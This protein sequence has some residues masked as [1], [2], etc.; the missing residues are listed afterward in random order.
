MSARPKSDI[1]SIVSE[2][3]VQCAFKAPQEITRQTTFDELGY[4]SLSFVEAVMTLEAELGIELPGAV[5]QG[6]WGG[7]TTIQQAIDDVVA[8]FGAAP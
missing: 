4:D 8:V 3:I 5:W 6:R 7:L 1:A 2:T